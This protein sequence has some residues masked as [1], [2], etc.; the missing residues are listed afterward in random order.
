MGKGTASTCG[1]LP[2]HVESTLF[3]PFRGPV[4]RANHNWLIAFEAE[5]TRPPS[6]W[7]RPLGLEGESSALRK[8]ISDAE[9]YKHAPGEQL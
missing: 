2:R 1:G 9:R 8:S 4:I 3:A 7:R 5:P 6:I